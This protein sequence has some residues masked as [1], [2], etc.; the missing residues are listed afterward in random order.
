[1]I[2]IISYLAEYFSMKM[3][4]AQYL[5]IGFYLVGG[6]VPVLGIMGDRKGNKIVINSALILLAMA[7]FVCG[8]GYDSQIFS[9]RIPSS[10]I[11]IP[12]KDGRSHSPKEYASPEDIALGARVLAD[13]IYKIAWKNKLPD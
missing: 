5:N 3:S 13:F 11:L 8:A 4:N 2:P 10:L 1:M 6:I 12:C 9:Y 7:T